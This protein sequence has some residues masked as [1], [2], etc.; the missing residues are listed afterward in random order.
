MKES[1][2]KK[3]HVTAVSTQSAFRA[4]TNIS[5]AIKL[6]KKV[7]SETDTIVELTRLLLI[8]YVISSITK[9]LF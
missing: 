9:A 8:A 4:I 2:D 5:E 6:S 3:N 1:K 7:G